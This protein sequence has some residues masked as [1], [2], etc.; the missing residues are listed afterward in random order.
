MLSLV[1]DIHCVLKNNNILDAFFSKWYTCVQEKNNII[2]AF[3]NKWYTLCTKEQKY[4][5]CFL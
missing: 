3:F 1:N 4:N 2:Y 5:R